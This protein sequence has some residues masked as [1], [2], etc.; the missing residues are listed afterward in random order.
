MSGK[1]L[2]RLGTFIFV[3][4]LTV[5]C[6]AQSTGRVIFLV[7]HAERAS[8]DRDSALSPEGNKRA[9]CLSNLL[10][11]AGVKAIFV[12]QF[13]RTQQTAEPLARKM[14][15]DPIIV[16]S[17]DTDALVKKV[18]STAAEAVLIVAHSDT[19]AG[20]IAKLGGGT[21][22]PIATDEYDRLFIL[23]SNSSNSA[24]VVTLRYCDCT[25]DNTPASK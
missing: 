2:S 14:G 11:D 5:P 12:T 20:I 17:A 18:H 3:L 4:L 15:V 24:P 22:A 13:A 8:Q 23:N 7:R 10:R 1:R 6:I 16:N 9:E 19:L 21:I 25:A